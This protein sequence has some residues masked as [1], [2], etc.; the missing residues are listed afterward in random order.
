MFISKSDAVLQVQN[1]VQ[2]VTVKLSDNQVVSVSGSTATVEIGEPVA[3]IRC[4]LHVNASTL[5]VEVA[6]AA[7]SG[8]S[9]V[10]TLSE[11]MAASDCIIVKYVVSEQA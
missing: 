1:K 9:I 11:P 2:E 8:T 3:D 6:S 7:I 4:V 10:C 5:A